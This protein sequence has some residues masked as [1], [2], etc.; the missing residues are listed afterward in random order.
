MRLLDLVA[1]LPVDQRAHLRRRLQTV[2]QADFAERGTERTFHLGKTAGLHQH[3]PCGG[4]LLA[5][6]DGCCC[7]QF[8][9]DSL[10][11][12]IL[13]DQATGFAAEFKGQ[14]LHG[15]C[16]VLHDALAGCGGASKAEHIYQRRSH[17]V[18]RADMPSFSEQVDRAGR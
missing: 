15:R 8:R 17:Q 1:R 3:A 14:L 5:G 10:D 9:C 11:V 7:R 16:G 12:G 6:N 4:A 13:E 18:R 2:A